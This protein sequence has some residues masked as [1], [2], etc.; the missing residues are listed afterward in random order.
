MRRQSDLSWFKQH[1]G[2]CLYTVRITA[3]EEVR[4]QRGWVFTPGIDDAESECDLDNM[5]DWDQE[6]D[7]SNDPGK[8]DELLH[9]LTTLC[10]QRLSSATRSTGKKI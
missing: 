1:Y 10:S 5:T 2:E 3:S 7:N 8:V 4:K 9:H 6:V